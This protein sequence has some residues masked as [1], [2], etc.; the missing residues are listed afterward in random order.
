[1]L[2]LDSGS[3]FIPP[4]VLLLFLA[5]KEDKYISGQAVAIHVVIH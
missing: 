2:L 1:M 5:I 4:S 3:C